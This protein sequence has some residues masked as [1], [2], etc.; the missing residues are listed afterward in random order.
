MSL[1]EGVMGV[2]I[3]FGAPIMHMISGLNLAWHWHVVCVHGHLRSHSGIVCSGGVLF[4]W[5]TM[6]NVKNR[7]FL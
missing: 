6:V 4:R 7:V 3:W 1:G 5:P 2:C